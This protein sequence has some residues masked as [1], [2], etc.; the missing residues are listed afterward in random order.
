MDFHFFKFFTEPSILGGVF[1]FQMN[2]WLSTWLGKIGTGLLLFFSLSA[3]IVAKFNPTLFRKKA[4]KI[5]QRKKLKEEK[6]IEEPTVTKVTFEEEEKEEIPEP[7][8]LSNNEPS[9]LSQAE[10]KNQTIDEDELAFEVNKRK[11]KK[12]F[13]RKKLKVK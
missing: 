4:Q 7:I 9:V 5:N 1:G 2:I 12:H 3:F 10:S 6:I 13:L 8:L 11:K